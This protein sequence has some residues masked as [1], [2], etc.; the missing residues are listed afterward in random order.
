[1]PINSKDVEKSVEKWVRSKYR[2]IKSLAIT[3]LWK[4]GDM[5]NVDIELEIKT[6]ILSSEKNMHSLQ[7]DASSGEIIGYK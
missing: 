1:M 5:W 4:E 3:K 2:N 7:V 6:G